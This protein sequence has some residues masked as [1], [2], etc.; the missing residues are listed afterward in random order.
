MSRFPSGT[1]D[2]RQL[3]INGHRVT[4][5]FSEEDAESKST[6]SETT[7]LAILSCSPSRYRKASQHQP[8]EIGLEP[9]GDTEWSLEW[10]FAAWM[11]EALLKPL[12]ATAQ[13]LPSSR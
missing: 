8:F 12:G 2:V 3:E 7:P 9:T 6:G 1:S 4:L 10:Q 5:L 13:A 11:L